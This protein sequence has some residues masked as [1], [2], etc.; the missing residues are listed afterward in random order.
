MAQCDISLKYFKHLA[1]H[2]L[3][4]CNECQYA[5]W[6]NQIEGHLQE[7]H[8]VK[9]KE[10]EAIGES[11]RCWSGLI[12]YPSELELPGQAREPF[13][14][15]PLYRDGM[16]CQLE[17]T[18][19]KHIVRNTNV[20]KKHWRIDHHYWSAGKKRG[21]PSRIQAQS[22]EAQIQ[23]GYK[24][25]YCQRFFSSR[26]G[27]QYFEVQLP[28]EGQQNPEPVPIDSEVAWA[29]VGRQMADV[30][31]NIKK[32][33]TTTIEN[34]EKDE[35]NPWL[36]RTGWLPYLIGLERPD[37]LASI[38]EPGVDPAKD[39]EPV[40]AAIWNAIEK[41]AQYSQDSVIERVGVFVRLEAIRTEHHQTRYQPLQPYMDE[42][43]IIKHAQRWQQIV[44][45]FAR[46]QREHKWNSPAY[47]FTRRQ[48]E[49]WEALIKQARRDVEGGDMDVG[50]TDDEM[51][52]VE[53]DEMDDDEMDGDDEVDEI[54]EAIDEGEEHHE[55]GHDTSNRSQPGSASKP[56]GLSKLQKACLKFCIALLN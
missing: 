12:Q 53:A 23:E 26:H 54:D 50:E 41:L 17:P 38:E 22:I 33:A 32:R 48:R 13:S 37:L 3:A 47:R 30:W 45:F 8:K 31:E 20:L 4:I 49:A 39:E 21:R 10:A 56:E 29:Q 36:Q 42:K 11:V 25:V 51:D 44:M 28:I 35:V 52:E 55:A 9:R 15:L 14:E 1:E 27:S 24:Q 34:G 16:L 18:R 5:V 19:C 43:A 46:T 6:P 2:Q 7:Q 40:E